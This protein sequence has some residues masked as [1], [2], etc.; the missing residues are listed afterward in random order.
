VGMLAWG[1]TLEPSFGLG[2]Y[3][4][5]NVPYINGSLSPSEL[6]SLTTICSFINQQGSGFG[7]CGSCQL[8]ALKGARN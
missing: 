6:T 7:I 5:V 2:A 1:S 4:P 8:G 3:A